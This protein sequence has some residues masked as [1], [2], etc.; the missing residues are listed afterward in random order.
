MNGKVLH[1]EAFIEIWYCLA[2][3][4]DDMCNF[5]CDDEFD[6]LSVARVT[7]AASW[8]PRK[9]PSLILIGPSKN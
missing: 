4:I 9:S 1:S 2:D 6:I 5:I 8:S 3:S 7:L